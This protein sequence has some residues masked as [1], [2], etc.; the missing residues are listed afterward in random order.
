M[1]I[2]NCPRLRG[3]LYFIIEY[4]KPQKGTCV[5][6]TR[7]QTHSCLYI[8]DSSE[9]VALDNITNTQKSLPRACISLQCPN[10][11]WYLLLFVERSPEPLTLVIHDPVSRTRDRYLFFTTWS[12]EPLSITCNSLPRPFNHSHIPAVHCP[13]PRATATLYQLPPFDF[14]WR[15]K[16][17]SRGGNIIRLHSLW[18]AEQLTQTPSAS[19]RR[20]QGLRL[21]WYQRLQTWACCI[22]WSLCTWGVKVRPKIPVWYKNNRVTERNAHFLLLCCLKFSDPVV[23]QVVCIKHT[24][25]LVKGMLMCSCRSEIN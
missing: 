1:I 7:L 22:I 11:R 12:A 6:C 25:S 18:M 14:V 3:Q 4:S 24:V 10:S 17:V 19:L 21:P 9:P 5:P 15:T 2:Y 16:S 23:K 20:H 13:V 8:S